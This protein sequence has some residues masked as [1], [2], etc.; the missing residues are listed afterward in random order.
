M[1][2]KYLGRTARIVFIFLMV[3]I[4]FYLYLPPWPSAIDYMKN[5]VG[6][7][8]V[9]VICLGSSHVFNGIDPK[10]MFYDKGIAAYDVAI[11]AQA[12]WQT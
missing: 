1:N 9:D 3:A 2:G 8:R 6:E 7:N 5:T 4:I 12:P 10:Q 11:G